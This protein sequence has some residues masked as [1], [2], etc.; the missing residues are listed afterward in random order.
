MAF[1]AVDGQPPT[2]NILNLD[3]RVTSFLTILVLVLLS[4]YV[5]KEVRKQNVERAKL[6]E[7][8]DHFREVEES[9][10]R[11][12]RPQIL[13]SMVVFPVLIVRRSAPG[14]IDRVLKVTDEV[15]RVELGMGG[16][17]KEFEGADKDA[18]KKKMLEEW[19]KEGE[20]RVRELFDVVINNNTSVPSVVAGRSEVTYLCRVF[21][22]SRG[23]PTGMAVGVSYP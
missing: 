14:G 13:G 6:R 4:I 21:S 3:M 15:V 9:T 8:R 12:I 1:G 11:C 5:G 7:E 16:D 23:G 19:G 20:K 22:G 18:G 10:Y 2:L 17:G